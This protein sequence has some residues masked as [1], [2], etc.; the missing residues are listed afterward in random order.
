MWT[1]FLLVAINPS[2]QPAIDRVDCAVVNHV[3][4]GDGALVL[5]QI[6]WQN[7]NPRLCRWDIVDWRMLIGCRIID[8][9]VAI[10][11]AKDNP[12]GPPYV[13]DWVGGHATPRHDGT[14]WVSDWYDEKSKKW[15]RVVATQVVESWTLGDP[16]LA[17]RE[18]L[19]EHLR[20]K[21]R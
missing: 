14:H 12:N 9:A 15:R 11:W 13:A 3:Y 18:I 19:A 4:N 10:Q 6:Y 16:E 5:D 8:E 2:W 1:A 17:G 7:W 21:L 20:R